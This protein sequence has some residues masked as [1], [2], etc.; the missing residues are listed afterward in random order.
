MH[1]VFVILYLSRAEEAHRSMTATA[2]RAR[3]KVFRLLPENNRIERIWLLAKTDFRKRYYGSFLGLIWAFINPLSQ[4]IIYYY[5][6]TIVFKIETEHYALFLFLGLVFWMFFNEATTKSIQL[7]K[8]KRYLLE[9]IQINRLDVYYAQILSTGLGFLFN[10][11]AY[12][13]AS[14]LF[15]ITIN[16]QVVFLPFVVLNLVLFILATQIILSVIHVFI[17]DIKHLW[18]IVSLVLFWLSGIVFH[19]DPNA[20]WK[21]MIMGYLTPLFGIFDNARAILIY[22]ETIDWNMFMYDSAYA[23]VLLGI[24]LFLMRRYFGKALEML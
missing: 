22:G 9:N 2:T 3:D 21:T 5:V 14:L 6:F 4:L 16:R 15:T 8:Q 20:T 13:L 12:F 11:S 7:V 19:I 10:F 24:G 17:R 18:A 1:E 23:L